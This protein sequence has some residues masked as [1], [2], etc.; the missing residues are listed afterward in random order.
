MNAQPLIEERRVRFSGL[1]AEAFDGIERGEKVT[2]TVVATCTET[3]EQDMKTEGERLTAT[4]KIDKVSLGIDS[5]IND[6][7][8]PEPNLFD[9]DPEPDSDDDPEDDESPSNVV[10]IGQGPQFSAGD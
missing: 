10:D 4:M 2:F 7:P 8:A 9:A 1:S 6:E 3:K 5:K